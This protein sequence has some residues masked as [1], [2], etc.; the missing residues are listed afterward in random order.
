MFF[1]SYFAN[2]FIDWRYRGQAYTPPSSVWVGMLTTT[3][4]PREN[5]TLYALDDTI[6]VAANDGKN[7]LYKCTAGGTSAATQGAIYSG[8]NSE[9][10]ADGTAIFTEQ[11][12]AL[13]AGTA[14][15]ASYTNYARAALVASLANMAGTQ[16]PG[17]TVASSG[18]NVPSTSNNA[19]MA[20]GT[21]PGSGPTHVWA[22]ATFDALAGGNMLDIQPMTTAKTIANADPVPTISTGSLVLSVDGQP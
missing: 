4:G 15:E 3:K 5:S 20:F 21:T 2:K 7:H 11:Y 6:S 18:T 16:G 1:T 19:P 8:A 10:V 17:T 9:V 14:V 13:R 22:T 12:A